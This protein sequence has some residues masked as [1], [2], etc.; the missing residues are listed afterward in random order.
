M[1]FLRANS[2][3]GSVFV[4]VGANVG[5]FSALMADK[6]GTIITFEPNEE[7][8]HSIEIMAR[9]NG[10]MATFKLH[11]IA[12]SDQPGSLHFL[13]EAMSSTNR[14]VSE[15]RANEANISIV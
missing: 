14:V 8:F 13:N 9:L 12:I 11:K 10:G 2:G 15:A 5:I 6:F 4:D 7:S 1:E 3:L